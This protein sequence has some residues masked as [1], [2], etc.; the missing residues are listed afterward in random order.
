MGYRPKTTLIT[1]AAGLPLP[2]EPISGQLTFPASDEGSARAC[3]KLGALFKRGNNYFLS[4]NFFHL[5]IGKAGD[6]DKTLIDDN[7]CGIR[8]RPRIKLRA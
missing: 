3:R 6:A 1:R 8:V 2:L 7:P 5:P 4:G